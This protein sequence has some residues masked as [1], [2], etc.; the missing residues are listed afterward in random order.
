MMLL[1]W[2]RTIR[3][4]KVGQL[5]EL[6]RVRLRAR[7]RDPRELLEQLADDGELPSVRW[8]PRGRWLAPDGTP[9]PAEDQ[10]T[11]RYCFVGETREVGHPPAW[12]D[13]GGSRLWRY[14]LHYHGFLFELEFEEARALVLDYVEVHGP[15]KGAVGW[16][17]YPLSLRLTSWIPLFFGRW[18]EETLAD[19]AF[20]A[21][22][23]LELRR[24]VRWL[25]A[26]L[27][28]HLLA[29]HLLEN[30]I[31]LSLAG[32]CFEGSEAA[33]WRERGYALLF[34]EREEQLLAD[35]GHH[36]RSPMYQQRV[37][38]GLGLLL[39]GGDLE[40]ERDCGAAARAMADWLRR[41]TH[42]DGGIALFNDAALGIYPHTAHLVDWLA[43]MGFES[44][45]V[46]DEPELLEPSGYFTARDEH[47]DALFLDV[48]EIG[49]DH[50]PGHAH[51]DFL[52]IELSVASRRFVVDGGN[53]DYEPGP[54]RAWARGVEAHSTVFVDGEEPLELW[55]AFRIGRRGRPTLVRQSRGAE[56]SAHCSA[57]HTG[58][59]HLPGAPRPCREA[60]WTERGVLHL[61]DCVQ[62]SRALPCTSQLRIDASWAIER[63][64]PDRLRFRCD[65]ETAWVLASGPIELETSRWYPRFGVERE[66]HLLRQRLV[67]GPDGPAVEWALCRDE[68]LER[69]ESL[70]ARHGHSASASP[71]P[72]PLP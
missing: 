16:E 10:R 24:M 43:G 58:Y 4:L 11:G 70:L 49:P 71:T 1:R 69:A 60:T 7:W 57:S 65:G 36:E 64:A 31:A 28:T 15:R 6:W 34:T 12:N 29:N 42:P 26:N 30:A 3:F 67:S 37:L 55:G 68:E 40:L 72:V 61:R 39:N 25:E 20:A 23:W 59:R 18:R 41:M 51:A 50:Q 2:L 66:S 32:A 14:N 19:E 27:E 56:G 54:R 5:I 33:G 9:H 22:L 35:G 52:S 17:P 48:G 53:H 46:S 62:A 63:V 44:A 21:R 13:E 38:Y 45:V 8:E 47:G